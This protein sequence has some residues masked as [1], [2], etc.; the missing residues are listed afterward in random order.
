MLEADRYNDQCEPMIPSM[1]RKHLV[2]ISTVV[3]LFF[4]THWN[5]ISLNWMR[6][7]CNIKLFR[8]QNL[9]RSLTVASGP[10]DGAINFLNE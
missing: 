6:M 2:F 3:R 1:M 7:I 5:L 10:S 8:H 4:V 9:A